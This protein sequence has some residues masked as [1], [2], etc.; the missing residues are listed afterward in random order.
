M[1]ENL[2]APP[3]AEIA[4]ADQ[5]VSQNAFY[6]VS[7]R[8]LAILHF[9]TIGLYPL[10][11]YYR[12]WKC[13]RDATQ[14]RIWPV[15]RAL[16]S[17]FFIHSLFR[18]V[19]AHAIKQGITL[20]WKNGWHATLLVSMLIFSKLLGRASAQSIGS[21]TTEVL[22]ALMLL[23]LYALLMRAQKHINTACGDSAGSSNATLTSA[24]Y[25]WIAL[26]LVFWALWVFGPFAS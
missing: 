20:G 18:K 22:G 12:N 8:K 4:D 17:Y 6:V 2:Y 1:T 23:P 7:T 19:Q 10:F 13:Y 14:T 5:P 24:N 15:A 21:P 26:G 11:W 25:I 3:K 16:F 9:S